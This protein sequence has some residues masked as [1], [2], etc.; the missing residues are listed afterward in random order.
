MGAKQ[1]E[2]GRG[3]TDA[4]IDLEVDLINRKRGIAVLSD[5]QEVPIVHWVAGDPIFDGDPEFA[6]SCVCGPDFD[7]KWYSVDLAAFGGLLA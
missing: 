3:M 1:K 2:K 6:V 5:G 7:G 4:Q